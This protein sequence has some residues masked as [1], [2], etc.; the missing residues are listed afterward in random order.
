MKQVRSFLPVC[1]LV[2]SGHSISQTKA[3]P[4]NDITGTWKGTSICQVKNSP[5]H[6]ETAVYHISPIPGS[7]SFRVRLNKIVNGVEEEMGEL[8]CSFNSSTTTLLGYTR[9]RQ[10]RLGEWKFVI[11][12]RELNGTLILGNSLLYRVIH[13]SKE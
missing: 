5:C 9:D 2:I 12:G 6:D 7:D 13:L 4:G 3:K 11:K 10:Q 8:N 1:L